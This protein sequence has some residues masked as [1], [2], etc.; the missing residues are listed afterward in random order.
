MSDQFSLKAVLYEAS[1]MHR[2]TP[3]HAYSPLL[4]GAVVCG[5]DITTSPGI[6][7][8][9]FWHSEKFNERLGRGGAVGVED[10]GVGGGLESSPWRS[11]LFGLREIKDKALTS[12]EAWI[13]RPGE[14]GG[15][16]TSGQNCS[17]SYWGACGLLCWPSTPPRAGAAQVSRGRWSCCCGD[18]LPIR[19][20]ASWSFCIWSVYSGT[21]FSPRRK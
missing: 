12:S 10:R 1:I 17:C 2:K 4:W 3:L 16:D 18:A 6:P 19:C 21:I 9:E 13:W 7:R 11:E 20:H 8:V 5:R 14:E 15:L